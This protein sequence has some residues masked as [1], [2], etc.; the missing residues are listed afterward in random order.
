VVVVPPVLS[1]AHWRVHP[2]G[3]TPFP[4]AHPGLAEALR[5]S[6]APHHCGGPRVRISLPPAKSQERT[7][8][9]VHICT[10]GELPFAAARNSHYCPP[11]TI[12][13]TGNRMFESIS[14][15]RRVMCE[16][17]SS[18]R[19]PQGQQ[20][21]GSGCRSFRPACARGAI[22]SKS[23]AGSES[24]RQNRSV[25]ICSISPAGMPNCHRQIVIASEAKQSCR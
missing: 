21:V 25:T 13:A 7:C 6:L 24:S 4:L 15:Q 23:S 1:I 16:P 20:R 2:R 14:L 17:D 19:A 18:I 8:L 3:L 10:D 5:T 9:V 22:A 11:M 12:S